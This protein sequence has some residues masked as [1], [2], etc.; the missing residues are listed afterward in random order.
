M[1]EAVGRIC[2]GPA[3]LRPKRAAHN[4]VPACA[5]LC[6]GKFEGYY[7]MEENLGSRTEF[8]QIT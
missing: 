6:H 3:R 4:A 2:H 5:T 7:G 8:T 1:T